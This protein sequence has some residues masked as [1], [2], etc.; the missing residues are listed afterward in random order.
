[1]TIVANDQ[2]SLRWTVARQALKAK[3]LQLK[4]GSRAAPA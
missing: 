2:L 1:M 4:G 3:W